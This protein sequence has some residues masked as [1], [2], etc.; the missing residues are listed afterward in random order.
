MSTE[1][2]GDDPGADEVLPALLLLTI[3][4]AALGALAAVGREQR[5]IL[6]ELASRYAQARIIDVAGAFFRDAPFIILDEPTAP[7][8]PGR[9]RAVRQHPHPVPGAVGAADLPSVLERPLGRPHLR[10][11]RGAGDRVG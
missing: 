8:R 9:A 6:A 11:G 4:T 5:E 3:V 10:P 1:A 7:G 2:V